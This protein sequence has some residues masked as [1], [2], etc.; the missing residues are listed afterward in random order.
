MEED[1]FQK[2]SAELDQSC[3]KKKAE[4]ELLHNIDLD[5][6]KKETNLSLDEIASLSGIKDSK[7]LGK[8]A[9][10]KPN[11]SRPNYNAIIRLFQAGATVETLFG[12]DYS[13]RSCA[14]VAVPPEIMNDPAFREGLLE[15]IKAKVDAVV[16]EQVTAILK[17]K[18]LL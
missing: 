4:E 3:K 15:S 11:G 18:G 7:N 16:S 8:W 17:D 12:V 1:L 2:N 5:A 14:S 10:G 13:D 9:Q 6:L